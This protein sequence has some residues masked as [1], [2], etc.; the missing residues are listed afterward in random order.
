MQVESV[1][2]ETAQNATFIPEYLLPRLRHLTT[3]SEVFVRATYARGLVRLANAAIN[4]LEISQAAKTARPE[5]EASDIT[6]VCLTVF[7]R[8]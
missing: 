4:M 2:S 8:C 3:D 5:V 7:S 1:T 6:E